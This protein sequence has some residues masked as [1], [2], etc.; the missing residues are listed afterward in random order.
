MLAKIV[1]TGNV[2]GVSYRY[3]AKKNAD[4]LGI[5]GYTK[6]LRN[7]DVEI[8]A[9][10]EKDEI[11]ALIEALKDGPSSSKVQNVNVEWLES[12]GLFRDFRI[13]Y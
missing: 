13:E 6:N 3:F 5:K 9:E 10:G 7:G 2:Q 4:K 11:E 1:V 8:Y 12:A